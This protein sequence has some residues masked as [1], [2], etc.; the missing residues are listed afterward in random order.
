MSEALGNCLRCPLCSECGVLCI[1]SYQV[2]FSRMLVLFFYC[3]FPQ[4]TK[5]ILTHGFGKLQKKK[6]F[7][8]ITQVSPL[9]HGKPRSHEI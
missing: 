4:G 8:Q 6:D 7:K 5:H 9:E 1:K 3:G 2:Y